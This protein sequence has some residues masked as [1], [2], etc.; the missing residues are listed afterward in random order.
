MNSNT[1]P[2]IVTATRSAVIMILKSL[3]NALNR[4]S[5]LETTLLCPNTCFSSCSLSVTECFHCNHA[6]AILINIRI[7]FRNSVDNSVV[8][9][10][11]PFPMHVYTPEEVGQGQKVINQLLAFQ[12]SIVAKHSTSEVCPH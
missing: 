4:L 6:A 10:T 3:E 9:Y 11:G 2:T 7:G 1:A 5:P 8:V 12:S